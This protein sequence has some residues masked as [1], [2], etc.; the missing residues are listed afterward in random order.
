MQFHSREDQFI[1]EYYNAKHSTECNLLL[2]YRATY[3]GCCTG[4]GSATLKLYCHVRWQAKW[5]SK[6][7]LSRNVYN[8]GAR[9][10]FDTLF[11][12]QVVWVCYSYIRM[13][14][15]IIDIEH[16]F[17]FIR[18]LLQVLKTRKIMRY[19]VIGLC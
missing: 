13:K 5:N 12:K 15:E 2:R 11:T 4:R 17:L 6:S 3:W 19:Y 18:L 7:C 10:V 8:N 1:I 9:C 14:F 16:F